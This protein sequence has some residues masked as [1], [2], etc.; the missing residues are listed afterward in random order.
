M[1]ECRWLAQDRPWGRGIGGH[2][3]SLSIV[4]AHIA[5]RQVK[6]RNLLGHQNL[7]PGLNP[8]HLVMLVLQSH[9]I[10]DCLMKPRVRIW[11]GWRLH[12]GRVKTPTM[13]YRLERFI[14]L[15]PFDQ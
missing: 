9:S 12:L 6:L 5:H 13:D 1:V 3:L 10:G 11:R 7:L 8:R 14:R 2:S 15:P 4:P